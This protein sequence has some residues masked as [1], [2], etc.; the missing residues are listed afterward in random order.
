MPPPSS[1]VPVG[2][3]H[4]L[5]DWGS[6]Q[7]ERLLLLLGYVQ[8]DHIQGTGEATAYLLEGPTIAAWRYSW[9]SCPYGHESELAVWRA[10]SF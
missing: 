10:A 2:Q 9:T 4:L 1:P 5:C 6:Q 3:G 8:C 7:V